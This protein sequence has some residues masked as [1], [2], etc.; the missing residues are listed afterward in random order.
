MC[1][2]IFSF[3]S[4]GTILILKTKTWR[5]RK[6]EKQ[7]KERFAQILIGPT[8]LQP[9]KRKKSIEKIGWKSIVLV[10]VCVF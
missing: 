9:P 8:S 7:K 1:I 4:P 3:A 2:S 10:H 6:V 5:N